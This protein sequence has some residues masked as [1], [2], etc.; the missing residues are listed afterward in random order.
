M[1]TFTTTE[2]AKAG[3]VIDLNNYESWDTKKFEVVDDTIIYP[4]SSVDFNEIAIVYHLDFN[5]RGILSKPISLKRLELASQAFNNNSFNPIGTRFGENLFP[6]TKSGFYYDYKAKNP[7]SIYKGSTPYLYLTRNSGIEVRGEY[8]PLIERGLTLPINSGI[9]SNYKVSAMQ[10]WVRYDKDQFPGS[11]V[12]IFQINHKDDT[13]IFYM[14]ANSEKGDRAKIFA[15][16]KNTG[17]EY[18]ALSYYLNGYLVKDPVLTI[19]EWAVIG[20]SFASSLSYDS[21]LGGIN[22]T[23]QVLFNNISYYQAN[24]LQQIQSQISRPWLRVKTNGIVN[25]DW[26]YW[27][28]NFTW[29]GVL[30]IVS[31]DLYSVNPAEVYKTYI[32]T[33]K[34][35]IDDDQGLSIDADNISLYK[36]ITWSSYIGTPV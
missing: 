28:N 21:Y 8:E 11:A 23:G 1:D 31:S 10:M 33:N 20:V 16:S 17:L 3:S 4:S 15:K 12:E 24:N 13:I 25:Y 18:N 6:Y 7:F 19:K 22:L 26:E 34:I 32:G 2:P 36:D 30:V 35:I 5:V 14:Q 9:A 27:D 29:N